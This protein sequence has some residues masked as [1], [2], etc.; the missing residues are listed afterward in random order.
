MLCW[1]QIRCKYKRRWKW[2][3][4]YLL[5]P[6]TVYVLYYR[7]SFPARSGSADPVSPD[8]SYIRNTRVN[9]ITAQLSLS[10]KIILHFFK[11]VDDPRSH[12]MINSDLTD[13]P[14][15]VKAYHIILIPTEMKIRCVTSAVCPSRDSYIAGCCTLRSDWS[16][17]AERNRSAACW[18][19]AFLP[20]ASRSRILQ[21]TRV[22][23]LFIQNI[24]FWMLTVMSYSGSCFWFCFRFKQIK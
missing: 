11:I 3:N 23:E 20:P 19:S 8:Q 2:R 18:R 5:D 21:D 7:P 24:L 17:Q 1:S 15:N 22:K 16:F 4:S 14:I 12:A 9:C 13:N 6:E 10:N